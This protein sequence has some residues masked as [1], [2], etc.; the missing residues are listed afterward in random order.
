ME[1]NIAILGPYCP[2]LTITCS[3][4][5]APLKLMHN[6]LT[7]YRPFP[8][9]FDFG[10]ETLALGVDLNGFVT[11]AA[12]CFLQGCVRCVSRRI[13]RSSRDVS[14]LLKCFLSRRLKPFRFPAGSRAGFHPRHPD[15]DTEFHIMRS[16]SD[17]Q[18]N[19]APLRCTEDA[20]SPLCVQ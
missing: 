4:G 12:Q 19:P 13:L 9:I 17:G 10:N 11:A 3:A 20:I 7:L 15:M 2:L 14:L 6:T 8:H 5:G 16:Q 1:T 18:I